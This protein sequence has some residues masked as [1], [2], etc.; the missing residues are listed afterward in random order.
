M[1][2]CI[3]E[4]KG[5]VKNVFISYQKSHPPQEMNP[6]DTLAIRAIGWTLQ[7]FSFFYMQFICISRKF[8]FEVWQ[9]STEKF[10]W[11]PNQISSVVLIKNKYFF[12]K[13]PANCSEITIRI[14]NREEIGENQQSLI[15]VKQIFLT[16]KIKFLRFIPL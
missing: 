13:S 1:R 7:M 16:H 11:P 4:L 10:W 5:H 3:Y 9:Y 6:I 12:L 8:H 14:W 15:K 2:K